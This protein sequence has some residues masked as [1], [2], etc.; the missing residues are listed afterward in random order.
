LKFSSKNSFFQRLNLKFFS[1]IIK[2][3]KAPE[4]N[5]VASNTMKLDMKSVDKELAKIAMED[6]SMPTNVSIYS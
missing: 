1:K 6:K 4:L 5:K 2:F 3:I